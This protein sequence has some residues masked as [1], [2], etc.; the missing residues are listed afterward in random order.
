MEEEAGMADAANGDVPASSPH[1]TS[2]I[3][4]GSSNQ[5]K[6]S[7]G[8]TLVEREPLKLRFHKLRFQNYTPRSEQLKTCMSA[9]ISKQVSA[10][11]Q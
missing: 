2:E 8:V 9:A 11:Q 1:Q 7:T 3:G 5:T 4:T 10:L 6:S